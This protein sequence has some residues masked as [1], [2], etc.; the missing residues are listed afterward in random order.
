MVLSTQCV[1]NAVFKFCE[2]AVEAGMDV[3]RVFGSLNYM[4][5]LT[6]VLVWK[7]LAMQEEW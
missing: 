4:P 2:L 7:L 5:N 6:Y 3:F 1:D